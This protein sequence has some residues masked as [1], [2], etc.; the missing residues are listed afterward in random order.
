MDHR[1][2]LPFALGFQPPHHRCVN[3][4][5]TVAVNI[6]PDFDALADHPFDREAAAIDQR[7]HIFDMERAAGGSALD[8]LSGFVHGDATDLETA[9]FPCGQRGSFDLY[10]KP[11][12][13][14]WFPGNV[15]ASG[16]LNTAILFPPLANFA[17]SRRPL[18]CKQRA[19]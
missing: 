11:F 18:P 3:L 9:Q 7:V 1:R 8:S 19:E 16:E 5:M 6:R 10:R 17:T 15:V 2:A 13:G 14:Q 4:V 12:N